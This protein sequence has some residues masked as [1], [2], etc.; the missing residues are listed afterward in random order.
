M[1]SSS[2]I[3]WLGFALLVLAWFFLLLEAYGMIAFKNIYSRM[4]IAALADTVSMILIFTGLIMSNVNPIA[5]TKVILLLL[6][7]LVMNPVTSHLIV[8]SARRNGIGLSNK[9]KGA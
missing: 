6:F 1:I 3:S 4:L 2:P 5:T 7:L 9:E 8:R